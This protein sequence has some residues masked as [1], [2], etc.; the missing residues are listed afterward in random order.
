MK[1]TFKRADGVMLGIALALLTL[2]G[3]VLNGTWRA[4]DWL[5]A[6]TAPRPL[7]V[8]TATVLP[9]PAL[10]SLANA[11]QAPLF[12]PDRHPDAARPLDPAASS[13]TGLTL[14][15]VLYNADVQLAFIKPANGPALKVRLNG[16]LPSGWTLDAI[17][18]T[19]ATFS[20]GERHETLMVQRL[21][22][23]APSSRPPL[24][25]SR[26][27]LHDSAP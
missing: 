16:Q 11:W 19:S 6:Q 14:T 15:G 4:V 3:L 9:R 12:S 26:E 13:L 20:L 7:I 10:S 25:L 27:D 24:S 17:T 1:I 8:A 2:I 5:P 21:R 22:L 18:P 23:P